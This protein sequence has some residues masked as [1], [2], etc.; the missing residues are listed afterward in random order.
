MVREPSGM[1]TTGNNDDAQRQS[2][3]SSADTS[4]RSGSGPNEVPAG[5]MK[6]EKHRLLLLHNGLIQLILRMTIL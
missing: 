1:Q 4:D 3:T 5:F 6:D 2:L